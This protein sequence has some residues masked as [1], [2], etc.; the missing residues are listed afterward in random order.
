MRS[1]NWQ[2]ASAPQLCSF[3]EISPS[4][5]CTHHFPRSPTKPGHKPLAGGLDLH[6][7]SRTSSA[8]APPA[9]SRTPTQGPALSSC[10]PCPQVLAKPAVP[11]AASHMHVPRPAGSPGLSTRCSGC[12]LPTGP[13]PVLRSSLPHRAH[14]HSSQPLLLHRAGPCARCC[15]RRREQDRARSPPVSFWAVGVAGPQERH[16]L[17]SGWCSGTQV[18]RVGVGVC[19]TQ[20]VRKGHLLSRH[21]RKKAAA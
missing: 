15:G 3:G 19:L 2:G 17:G 18:S 8:G 9:S 4:Y 13:F 16:L 5:Q 12:S 1:P 21:L 7:A 6:R 11:W 10:H 20:V 14:L